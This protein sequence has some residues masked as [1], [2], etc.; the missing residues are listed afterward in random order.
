MTELNTYI[1]K[2]AKMYDSSFQDFNDHR[3]TVVITGL[4]LP[5]RNFKI[6]HS[7]VISVI[8]DYTSNKD[9]H[10]S[11]NVRFFGAHSEI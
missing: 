3:V 10:K 1:F 11:M 2:R 5:S 7:F 8:N 4:Y 9:V 6:C